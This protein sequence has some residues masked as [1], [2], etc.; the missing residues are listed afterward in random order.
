MHKTTILKEFTASNLT[1]TYKTNII[2]KYFGRKGDKK[3]FSVG[4]KLLVVGFINQNF[5]VCVN[6]RFIN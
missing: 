5:V 3:A 2:L 4:K 1:V 6:D